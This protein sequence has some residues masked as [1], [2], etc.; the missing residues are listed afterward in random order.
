MCA[1]EHEVSHLCHVPPIAV[2]VDRPP[3]GS[4]SYS[5]LCNT[6]T[7]V[8]P[9][10][11][12]NRSQFTPK[13]IISLDHMNIY[14]NCR[15]DDTKTKSNVNCFYVPAPVILQIFLAI[16]FNT[17]VLWTRVP[18]GIAPGTSPLTEWFLPSRVWC[19]VYWYLGTT[20]FEEHTTSIILTFLRFAKFNVRKFYILPSQHISVFY[21]NDHVVIEQNL[22]D[23]Y[24]RDD[25]CFL[26]GA[27]W[28][29][30]YR[31][32]DKSLAQPTSKCILF[33]G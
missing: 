20:I 24:N 15:H 22:F 21:K 9:N 32:A 18:A 17:T 25:V 23:F 28:K 11:D 10:N 7:V 6:C 5:L 8:E 27:N 13:F 14:R 30:V 4:H 12:D 16:F 19:R 2:W 1:H 26:G 3:F 29:F 33:D 31:S